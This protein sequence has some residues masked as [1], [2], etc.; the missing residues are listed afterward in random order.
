MGCRNHI[1]FLDVYQ[2][3]EDLQR[4]VPATGEISA[5][6]E[7]SSYESVGR[8]FAE[9]YQNYDFGV[10]DTSPVLNG[11]GEELGRM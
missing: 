3:S 2:K 10:R 5:S 7:L 1:Y 9:K 11:N 4:I 6:K 8:C